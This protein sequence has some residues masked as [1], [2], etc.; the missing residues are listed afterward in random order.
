MEE[1]NRNENSKDLLIDFKINS[2]NNRLSM[3]ISKEEREKLE[4]EY[5]RLLEEKNSSN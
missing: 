1:K 2:I 4:E 3:E 5:I